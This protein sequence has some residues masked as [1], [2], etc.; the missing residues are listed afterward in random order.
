M[1]M[2]FPV[3]SA[4]TILFLISCDGYKTVAP[5]GDFDLIPIGSYSGIPFEDDPVAS[6]LSFTVDAEGLLSGNVIVSLLNQ[7]ETYSPRVFHFTGEVEALQTL[8]VVDTLSVLLNFDEDGEF[9]AIVSGYDIGASNRNPGLFSAHFVSDT[10][11]VRPP[12]P[13]GTL[14]LGDG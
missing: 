2:F 6:E 8:I 4:L 10:V 1:R 14:P 11:P 13:I 7:N 5:D 12:E 9:V 3:I